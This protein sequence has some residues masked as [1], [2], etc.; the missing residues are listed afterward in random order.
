M[1]WPGPDSGHQEVQHPAGLL[2][3]RASQRGDRIALQ[4]RAGVQTRQPEDPR[5]VGV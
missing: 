3:G 1:I 2:R 5:G 4:V